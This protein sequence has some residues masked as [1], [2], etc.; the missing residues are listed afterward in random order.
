MPAIPDIFFDDT[1][2]PAAGDVAA[3]GSEQG[4][5]GHRG[6]AQIDDAGLAFPDL[7]DRRLHI[8]V[9]AAPGNA[10]QGGKGSGVGGEQHFV[11][12]VG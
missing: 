11:A 4:V 9:D 7:V 10:A 3:I 6:K 5:R 2:L 8:V 12:L 1:F